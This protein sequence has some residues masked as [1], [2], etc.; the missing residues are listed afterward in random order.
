[1][2][3]CTTLTDWDTG[4]GPTRHTTDR[5]VAFSNNER[6]T[7][8]QGGSLKLPAKVYANFDES[9]RE[10]ERGKNSPEENGR[11][12]LFYV[13]S[14]NFLFNIHRII[15]IIPLVL[16]KS[17]FE[18]LE[19][20]LSSISFR[21]YYFYKREIVMRKLREDKETQLNQESII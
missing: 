3:R 9:K 7:N 11:R 4:T 15:K 21:K 19:P 12:E 17:N 2:H 10:K 16:S 20:Q 14:L 5:G 8:A 18:L 6:N 13:F 1:M